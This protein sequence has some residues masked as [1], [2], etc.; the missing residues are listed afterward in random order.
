MF[1][2]SSISTALEFWSVIHNSIYKSSESNV[3]KN[4][5]FLGE[6]S[7]NWPN[8]LLGTNAYKTLKSCWQSL[9][10]ILQC[11]NTTSI[12]SNF[13]ICFIYNAFK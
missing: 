8:S 3:F 11:T 7:N 12:I 9:L 2:L 5:K 1:I 10:T 13:L 4:I 6:I